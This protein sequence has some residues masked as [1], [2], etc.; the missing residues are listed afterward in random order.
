MNYSYQI[1]SPSGNETALV[2]TL[3]QDK[4]ERQHIAWQILVKHPQVEQVGF[5]DN[6]RQE[7]LMAGGEFCG[8]ALRAAAS[9][10]LG[11]STGELK[12]KVHGVDHLLKAGRTLTGDIYAQMLGP[13]ALSELVQ[14]QTDLFIVRLPGIVHVVVPLQEWQVQDLSASNIEKRTLAILNSQ[15]LMHEHAAGVIFVVKESDSWQIVPCVRVAAVD[16]LVC[17]SACGSGTIAVGV[18]HAMLQKTSVDIPIRQPS[19]QIIRAQVCCKGDMVIEGFISGQVTSDGR[20]Y[21][22]NVGEG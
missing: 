20:K 22:L 6:S 7:L 5:W 18:V 17:E 3:V 8:N 9:C 11:D 2:Q 19:G 16:T 14:V 13:H 21:D 15:G 1:Y 12:V 4:E 10:Y